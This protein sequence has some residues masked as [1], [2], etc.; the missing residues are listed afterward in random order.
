L[1]PIVALRRMRQEEGNYWFSQAYLPMLAVERDR[2]ITKTIPSSHLSEFLLLLLFL[3]L[4]CF[5]LI[6]NGEDF[7]KKN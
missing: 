4:F 3:V 7:N 6:L 2:N 5:V 1:L